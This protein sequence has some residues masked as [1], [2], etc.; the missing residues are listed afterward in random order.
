MAGWGSAPDPT[1]GAYSSPD[2]IARLRWRKGV[3]G[4][5]EKWYLRFWGKVTP[6]RTTLCGPGT[7]VGPLCA[8]VSTN[9]A[10]RRFRVKFA[11]LATIG[12]VT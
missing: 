4:G 11:H 2:P 6:L 1:V 12:H 5:K 3:T 8:S 10:D 9:N 7:V